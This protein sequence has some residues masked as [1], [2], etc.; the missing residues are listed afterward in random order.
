MRIGIDIGGTFTDFV[1]FDPSTGTI[2]TFKLLSTPNNPAEAMLSGLEQISNENKRKIIHGS[3][4]ATNALLERKGAPTALISTKGF[5]DVLHI[6][7]QNRPELYDFFADPPP[8]LVP[9]VWRLEVTERVN[10]NGEIQTPLD[11]H[12]LG[13]LI[14]FLKKEKILSVAVSLLF[15]FLSPVH[16]QKIAENLQEAGFFTSKSSDILPVF[17]EYERTSTTVI[18]A[19]VSPILDTYLEELETN[20]PKDDLH[21]MQ[22]NGGSISPTEARQNAV[23]C[24]LSGPAGGVVGAHAVASTAGYEKI[25]TFDMGGTSTDVSLVD[26]K[27]QVITEADVGGYPVRV[28]L[29][30]IHIV[31][32]GGG[33]IARVDAGGAL[34]VGPE[35]AGADPGP[36]CYGK[37]NQPTVTDANLIL[38]RIAANYFLGGKM[39]LDLKAAQDT[40][41]TLAKE[42]GL[43]PEQ[44]AL[45]V[46]R[47]ANA[48]M[49]RAL[50]V[51]SIERGH[52][53][54]NFSLLSFG[55]AGGLHAVELARG[56]NIP[57]VIVPPQAA[58]LS[59]L[60]MLMADIVKDYS[61][62]IMLP[63]DTT[64]RKIE[65][66]FSPLIQQGHKEIK[67]EGIPNNKINIERSLDIR[68]RGQSFEL[69]IP[70]NRDFLNQFHR[71]HSELYGYANEGGGIEIVNLRVKAIGLVTK[72]SLPELTC[73]PKKDPSPAF[74][75]ESQVY[76]S[77]GRIQTPFYDGEKL[78]TGNKIKG[79]AI[80][81]RPD[82]TVLIGINDSGLV[83][84]FSNLIVD[85]GEND[86]L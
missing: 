2:T 4:V 14:Q 72:P 34:R 55:G 31:G 51:I 53:P 8:P 28:P 10:H 11:I 12:E 49:E 36:A 61:Q 54:R 81:L 75:H 84:R 80:I 52:D 62:T 82:T 15:S 83:D 66:L 65:N 3:T 38:G 21:I 19:Y 13:E 41:R 7:R 46:V 85:I 43:P 86:K 39:Q 37:G 74:L 33:S 67:S 29:L 68:Y 35:S 78:I 5:R 77:T 60:G 25:I 59:A 26:E 69:T 48:H 27:I 56:L 70:F 9:D 23:R 44:A 16:E 42:L 20:L 73:T 22:S 24:I 79:P 58:T 17:R 63:G 47:V 50:R 40:F 6:G 71:Y 32:S 64:F 1:C 30:D 76:F 57:R 45:G 18:N